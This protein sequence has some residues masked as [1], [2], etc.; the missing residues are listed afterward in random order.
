MSR[1]LPS[2]VE[3]RARIW[4]VYCYSGGFVGTVLVDLMALLSALASNGDAEDGAF[5]C[6]AR[7]KDQLSCDII[8]LFK[9]RNRTI[10]SCYVAI[11]IQL[12]PL[13]FSEQGE[14]ESPWS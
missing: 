1:K 7:L 11:L 2:Q 6:S 8:S 13:E 4:W 9:E 5:A 14:S 12:W 3:R 10:R